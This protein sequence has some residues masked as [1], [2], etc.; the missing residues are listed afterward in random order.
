MVKITSLFVLCAG[1]SRCFHM[2]GGP[3]TLDADIELNVVN[4]SVQCGLFG[5]AP[6]CTA[7]IQSCTC[8]C[9][10]Q[11]SQYGLHIYL[12]R[13]SASG[14][15][16]KHTDASCF[17]DAVW[18][19][20]AKTKLSHK[21]FLGAFKFFYLSK[22]WGC[23]MNCFCALCLQCPTEG[24]KAGSVFYCYY[25]CS[26]HVHH[27]FLLVSHMMVSLSSNQMCQ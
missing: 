2:A 21:L 9:S 15:V 16:R 27:T 20:W 25:C 8:C 7:C 14:H 24:R 17:R 13:D 19:S 26:S 3:F 22:L 10:S 12:Q 4:P 6:K 11:R 18:T 1:C 5:D 23:S